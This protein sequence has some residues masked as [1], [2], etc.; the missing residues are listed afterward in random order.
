MPVA[1]AVIG[2]AVRSECGVE[3]GTRQF[4][5]KRAMICLD[6]PVH[7]GRLRAQAHNVNAEFAH[8]REGA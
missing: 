8:L 5:L 4:A 3:V 2:G 1:I 6:D 7:V